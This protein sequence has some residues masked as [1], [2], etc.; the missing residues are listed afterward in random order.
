M[1][2]DQVRH[3]RFEGARRMIVVPASR[4]FDRGSGLELVWDRQ[5]ADL[6]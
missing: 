5:S 2:E 3:I 6:P 4:L 1:M